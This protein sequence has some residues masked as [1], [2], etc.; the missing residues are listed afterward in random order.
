MDITRTKITIVFAAALFWSGGELSLAQ[1]KRPRNPHWR[2]QG[3][4]VDV[5]PSPAQTSDAAAAEVSTEPAA[6][7]SAPE[8]A[9]AAAAAPIRRLAPGR[10]RPEVR[11]A[12]EEFMA[13]R[14][15][16]SLLYDPRSP[17]TAVLAF[18]D[19]VVVNDV[20]EAVFQRMVER[21]DFRF[22]DEF[23]RDVPLAYGRQRLRAAHDLFSDLPVSVWPQQPAYHQYRKGFLKAYRD[24]CDKLGRLECRAWLVK[25]MR[26]YREEEIVFYTM[27]AIGE[28]HLRPV[29]EELVRDDPEDPDPV[30]IRRGL[31]RIPEMQELCTALRES[32]FEI[33][34]VDSAAQPELEA[35]ARDYEVDPSRV[36]G[37]R[38]KIVSEKFNGNIIPPV[39]IRGGKTEILS[40]KLGPAPDLSVGVGLDDKELLEYGTG[41]RLL[42]D[43]G[44]AGMRRLAVEKNW[45]R[46]PAFSGAR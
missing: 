24:M 44:D 33:W 29:V 28:E 22:S 25:L 21:A 35:M 46:Q 6:G 37:V 12:L 42:L 5:R 10:W 20:G 38:G 27:T 2:G 45:L 30:I 9:P 4:A 41:L 19:A 43:R 39:P 23:W 18:S 34:F 11:K 17:P 36:W 26:G 16:G 40:A 8:S 13:A 3:K 31:A 7:G 14:G 32:G 15:K 1:A